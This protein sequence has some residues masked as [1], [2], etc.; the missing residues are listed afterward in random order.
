MFSPGPQVVIFK[1]KRLSLPLS[2]ILFLCS[3]YPKALF[4]FALLPLPFNL[5]RIEEAGLGRVWQKTP[6]PIEHP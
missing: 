6:L 4:F 5:P 1:L 3:I 2:Q